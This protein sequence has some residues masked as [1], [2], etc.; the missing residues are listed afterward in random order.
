MHHLLLIGDYIGAIE[1]D[2]DKHEVASR[3]EYIGRDD[4][5]FELVKEDF[6][7]ECFEQ[8][9]NILMEARR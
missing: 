2:I 5:E 8:N 3:L 4:K 7:N 9:Q 6:M 1:P